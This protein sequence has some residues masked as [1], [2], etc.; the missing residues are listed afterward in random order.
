MTAYSSAIYAGT[1]VHKRLHPKAHAFSYR[2]FSLSLDVDEIGRL[3]RELRL[4]SRGRRNLLSFLDRDLGAPGGEPIA[5]KARRLLADAG[6]AQYGARIELVCY[7]R[8]MGYVFNPLSVYFCRDERGNLGA[9]VYE[10]T[11]TFGERKSYVIEVD[12]DGSSG[13]LVQSCAK[14][15]YVSPY[16]GARG[17]YG[18]HILPPDER[19]VIGVT[20]REEGRPVLKTHFQGD[21]IALSDGN[22]ARLIVRHPMMTL[23]IISAI[24]FEAARLWIKGV[25]LVARHSSPAFSF[26]VV[27]S[28]SQDGLHA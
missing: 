19:V 11:N 15:M 12:D 4:F 21:R 14:E 24:H 18:F 26:T 1:V 13:G 9:V 23:K 10:V 3:D 17:S 16:T 27:R 6:L 28:Q 8:V 25:P 2:V 20:F 22:I 5:V 7:P